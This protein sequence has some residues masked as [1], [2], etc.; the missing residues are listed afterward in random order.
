M[1]SWLKDI[2][3]VYLIGAFFIGAALIWF[4]GVRLEKIAARLG[5]VTGLGQ[6]FAGMILLAVATS[7]PEIAT[8]MTATLR[9]EVD[10]AVFNILGSIVVQTIILSLAD[11]I[12]K[13]GALTG[14]YPSFGLIIQGCGLLILLAFTTAIITVNLHWKNVEWLNLSGPAAIACM[15]V[16]VQFV[17]MRAQKNPR[18][19]PSSEDG[20]ETEEGYKGD[21]KSSVKSLAWRFGLL[22]LIILSA[23]FVTVVAVE[24]FAERTGASKNFLGFALVSLVTSL[25]EVGT[26][27]IAARR[28]RGVTAISNIFGSNGFVLALLLVIALLHQGN[29]FKEQ[30]IPA[31]FACAFGMLL[32]LIYLLGMLE[33]RDKTIARMGIDSWLVLIVGLSGMWVMFELFA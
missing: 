1:D 9:G 27:L 18:W 16:L 20:E 28:A 11:A 22:S 21:E 19:K 26:T 14:R 30:F 33:R 29:I 10:I 15:Y 8:S 4:S 23:G 3:L 7:L 17:V 24:T 2:S 6:V 32:T 25:P 5:N 13:K 12:G 31:I